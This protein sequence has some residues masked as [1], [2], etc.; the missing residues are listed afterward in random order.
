MRILL[1][2]LIGSWAFA[3]EPTSRTPAPGGEFEWADTSL[4]G[5]GTETSLKLDFRGTAVNKTDR[6]WVWV[7]FCV[8]AASSGQRPLRS[9]GSECTID[10]DAWDVPLGGRVSWKFSPKIAVGTDRQAKLAV[11]NFEIAFVDGGQDS[12]GTR[13]FDQACDAVWGAALQSF[14]DTG[15]EPQSSD[16][17]GGVLK[18]QWAKGE[19][20]SI[21]TADNDVRGLTK[22]HTGFF[23]QYDGFRVDSATAL[24]LPDS[25]CKIQV[26]VAYAGRSTKSGWVVL[27]SNG[28]M[29][30]SVLDGMKSRLNAPAPG[31]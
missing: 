27:E 6:A 4:K 8:K 15:F 5:S 12:P 10:L 17:A 3:A 20:T 14:M 24:F 2:L 30:R 1:A 31:R 13:H 25:G 9:S 11:E 26:K 18:L 16:R 29:E 19:N 7:K 21:L 28:K 22:A 23:D